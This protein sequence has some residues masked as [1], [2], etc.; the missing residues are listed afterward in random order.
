M[1]HCN[2]G[3]MAEGQ[4]SV[5]SSSEAQPTP[6]RQNS[7][8]R[9]WCCLRFWTVCSFAVT[10]LT[11]CFCR[12]FLGTLVSVH[13][14]NMTQMACARWICRK[15]QY[16]ATLS[17]KETGKQGASERLNNTAFSHREVDGRWDS[18]PRGL[19]HYLDF[20]SVRMTKDDY[21]KGK[22]RRAG[23]YSYAPF[24]CGFSCLSLDA[25]LCPAVSSRHSGL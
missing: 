12:R 5:Q 16:I 14:R 4:H 20:M 23:C 6:P 7:A 11:G 25:P 15:P 13:R 10:Q 3:K 21:D 8:C 22:L 19:V 18:G 24:P 2:R 17:L 1:L 9:R